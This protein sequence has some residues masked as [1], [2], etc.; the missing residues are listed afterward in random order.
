MVGVLNLPWEGKSGTPTNF[1]T[2]RGKWVSRTVRSHLVGVLGWESH[3]GLEA[4]V[5]GTLRGLGR[6]DR[7]A[8]P[9]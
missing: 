1:R 3:A 7:F 2:V 8:Q 9:V 6:L 5:E 4:A